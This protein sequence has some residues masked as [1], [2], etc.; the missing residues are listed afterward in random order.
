MSLDLLYYMNN[1]LIVLVYL[2]LFAALRK[3][4]FANMLIAV[5]I[6]F[7]GI[8]VYYTSAVGFEMLS[9]SKQYFLRE[10]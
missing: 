5:I 2:G 9:A 7:I 3:L 10:R 1:G 4:D 6:G 8:A